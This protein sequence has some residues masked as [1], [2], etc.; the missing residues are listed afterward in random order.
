MSRD[1][2]H[3]KIYCIRNNVD[4]E[5][6]IGSTTQSLSKRMAKHRESID[7]STKSHF[8][9]YEKMRDIGIENCYIEL[10]KNYPCENNEQLRA[11]EGKIMRV[12][13]TLNDRVECRTRKERYEDNKEAVLEQNKKWRDEHKEEQK[14]YFKKHRENNKDKI[15]ARAGEALQCECGVIYT[16]QHKSRHFRTKHHQEYLKQQKEI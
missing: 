16:R 3:G 1:Y 15:K 4:D 5:I 2:S 9:L 7:N 8:R 11:E 6:Y 10:V 12:M 13:A 14:E